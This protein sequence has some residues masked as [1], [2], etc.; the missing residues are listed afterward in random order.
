MARPSHERPELRRKGYEILKV[1]YGIDRRF[2]TK[3]KLELVL[4]RKSIQNWD[5]EEV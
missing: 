5:N 1:Y 3:H 2:S 4:A